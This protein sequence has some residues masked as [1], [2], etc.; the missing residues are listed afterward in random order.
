MTLS[1]SFTA[2]LAAVY[3]C[4]DQHDVELRLLDKHVFPRLHHRRSFLDAG[5]GTGAL[6]RAIGPRFGRTEAIEPDP[7]NV[8][9]LERLGGVAAVHPCMVGDFDPGLSRFDLILSSHV[10][11]YIP[12][13]DWLA[14][15]DRMASW[16][17]PGGKLA[18]IVQSETGEAQRFY[19]AFSSHPPV[20]VDK[21]F[22]GIAAEH[23]AR[24]HHGRITFQ[25]RD[26]EDFVA[27]ACLTLL[28]SPAALVPTMPAIRQYLGACASDDGWYELVQG[29]DVIVV[30]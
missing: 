6:A 30:G 3:A 7:A 18:I 4:S 16:L 2:G 24:L 5:A 20:P 27:A 10:L 26:F 17:H 1:P 19:D 11:Y 14:T 28:D 29:I 9:E 21:L 15:V 8:D 25:T 23:P 12:R 13:C 22:Q